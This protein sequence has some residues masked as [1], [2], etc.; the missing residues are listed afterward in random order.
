MIRPLPWTLR[1]QIENYVR[2]VSDAAPAI[3]EEAEL[4]LTPKALDDFLFAAGLRK[5][6]DLVESQYVMLSSALGLVEPHGVQRVDVGR[7]AFSRESE[8]YENIRRIRMGL[9][10]RLV[11]LEVFPIVAARTLSEV[12]FL[13]ASPFSRQ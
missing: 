9:Y 1:E 2:T 3:F 10:Q 4:E 12:A 8:T 13:T 6:W 5:L 11:A 7:R